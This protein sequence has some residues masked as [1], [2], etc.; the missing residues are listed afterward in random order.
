[1]AIR[2]LP[3]AARTPK[4]WKNG[5]GV[6]TDVLVWPERAGL[7]DF[8]ARVSIAEV[9]SDGPFSLFPGIDRTTSILS[10]QGFDL[11]FENAG[12]E[13][14]TLDRA[15]LDYPGDVPAVSRLIAGPVTDL[16]AM[17]RR[18]KATHRMEKIA[19]LPGKTYETGR[20]SL[21][22]AASG[23]L[24]LSTGSAR[25]DLAPLD[26][27]LFENTQEFAVAGD[28]PATAYRITFDLTRP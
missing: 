24:S 23:G 28:R 1:M 13:R 21:L 10:G 15:P 3:A 9:A 5:G 22:L 19:L 26:A 12:T 20:L 25:F 8:I 16:N 18:G 7:E 17:T 4:P 6:T 14:L 2:F 11:A 27:L